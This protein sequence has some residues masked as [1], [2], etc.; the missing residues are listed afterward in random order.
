MLDTSLN[1]RI[2]VPDFTQPPLS[3]SINSAI[4]S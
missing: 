2:Y 1:F 3:N 4:V